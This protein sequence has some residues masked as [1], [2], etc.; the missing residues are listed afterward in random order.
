MNLLARNLLG[1]SVLKV[2]NCYKFH[3]IFPF[4]RLRWLQNSSD[5]LKSSTIGQKPSLK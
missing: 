4:D 5:P 2:P 3:V 1:T